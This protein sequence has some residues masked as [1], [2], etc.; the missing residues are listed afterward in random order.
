MPRTNTPPTTKRSRRARRVVGALFGA[1]ALAALSAVAAPTASAATDPVPTS[2]DHKYTAPGVT[3]YVTEY[4]DVVSVCDTAANGQPAI[5]GVSD[6]RGFRYSIQ[7]YRG[8]RSCKTY[9]AGNAGS[10]TDLRE[11][12]WINLAYVGDGGRAWYADYLNDH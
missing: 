10:T 6:S 11:G 1:A 12:D 4:G 8:Y 2:W 9:R 3:V 5:V 7:N